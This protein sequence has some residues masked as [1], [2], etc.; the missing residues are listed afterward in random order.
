[1]EH[2]L[3]YCNLLH[4]RL[5]KAMIIII[6]L[7]QSTHPYKRNT[8]PPTIILPC[9]ISAQ[10]PLCILLVSAHHLL[11]FLRRKAS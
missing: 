2:H 5:F 8:Y 10:Q 1:M 3:A 11:G 9:T 7:S 6:T 4:H